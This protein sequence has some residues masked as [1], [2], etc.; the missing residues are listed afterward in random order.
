MG[1]NQWDFIN[2][3]YTAAFTVAIKGAQLNTRIL[4]TMLY[5]EVSIIG[6]YSEHRLYIYDNYAFIRLVG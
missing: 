5:A 6:T 1:L 4:D 2:T 3:D